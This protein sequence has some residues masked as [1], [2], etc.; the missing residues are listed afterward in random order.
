MRLGDQGNHKP[1]QM[2]D[3]YLNSSEAHLLIYRAYSMGDDEIWAVLHVCG[4]PNN[5]ATP[6]RACTENIFFSQC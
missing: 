1:N 4:T 5:S 3:D 6:K 2:N